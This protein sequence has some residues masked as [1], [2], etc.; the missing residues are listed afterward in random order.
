MS[1]HAEH[2]LE[3][4]FAHPTSH[5]IH[6]RDIVHMFQALGAETDETKKDHL[7]VKLAG[8][9][10]TFPIPKAGNH[11]LE[12]NHEIAAMRRFLKECGFGPKSGH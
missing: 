9:E 11:T 5:N 1:H 7:K 6:W 10:M 2:T 3:Q 8:K 12:D 4:L